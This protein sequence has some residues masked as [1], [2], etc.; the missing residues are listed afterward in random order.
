M[1]LN[2]AL[3]PGVID[4]QSRKFERMLQTASDRNMPLFLPP[5]VYVVSNLN[6]PRNVRLSG[7]PGATRIIYGG[8]GHLFLAEQTELLHLD[9]AAVTAQTA[10]S[11]TMPKA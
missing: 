10:G 3:L 9:G 4:N 2:L 6:L 11:A 1:P 8:D 7:V 5:G